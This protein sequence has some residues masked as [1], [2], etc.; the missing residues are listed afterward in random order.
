MHVMSR[1]THASN[2]RLLLMRTTCI[3]GVDLASQLRVR[4]FAS[5][6]AILSHE[7]HVRIRT[8]G[9]RI[10]GLFLRPHCPLPGPAGKTPRMGIDRLHGERSMGVPNA[11]CRGSLAPLP[12]SIQLQSNSA[13]PSREQ[14]VGL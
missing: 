12:Y 14:P 2:A 11:P 7:F 10:S 6:G 3:S 1:A 9:A 13:S 8:R 5:F 4:H